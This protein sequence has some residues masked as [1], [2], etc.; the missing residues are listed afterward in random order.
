MSFTIHRILASIEDEEARFLAIRTPPEGKSRWTGDDASRRVG[1]QVAKPI[2]PQE[3]VS[4]IH[5]LAREDAVAAVVA[6]DLLRRPAVVAQVRQEDRIS[7][8]HTLVEDERVAAVVTGDLLRRPT[9][10]AQV[11]QEDRV[12]AG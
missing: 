11:R 7:A 10:V 1:R 9:V 3:K 8:A 2:T 6:G 4:A 12:R 5:T